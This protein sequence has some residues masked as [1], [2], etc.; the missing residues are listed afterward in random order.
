M[1][2]LS[3]ATSSASNLTL[4]VEL[5]ETMTRD[6]ER[7]VQ[8]ALDNRLELTR[9][10]RAM[11]EMMVAIPQ[12]IENL[13]RGG[14]ATHDAANPNPAPTKRKTLIKPAPHTKLAVNT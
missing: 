4:P 6:R 11:T 5:E 7:P 2:L 3:P 14:S 8:H 10:R 9:E 13:K 12:Q 1:H